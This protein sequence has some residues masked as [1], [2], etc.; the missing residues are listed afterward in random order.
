MD[1]KLNQSLNTKTNPCSNTLLKLIKDLWPIF[2]H[3]HVCKSYKKTF[4]QGKSV[5][6]K[7]P[8]IFQFHILYRRTSLKETNIIVKRDILQ[9]SV[10]I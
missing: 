1:S 9:F 4:R 8:K 10:Y 7:N 2:L 5:N 3:Y 6:Y